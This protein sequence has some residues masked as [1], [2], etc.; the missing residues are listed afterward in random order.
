MN[1]PNPPPFPET[2]DEIR[3]RFAEV[4]R[5]FRAPLI[6]FLQR[7]VGNEHCAADLA[8]E[9]LVKS[10]FQLDHFDDRR[11]FRPWLFTIAANCG[12][13][14]IRKHS[15]SPLVADEDAGESTS[16]QPG[17]DRMMEA[18]ERKEALDAAI[19]LLPISLRQ[20]ILLHYQLDWPVAEISQHLGIDQGAVKT[21]LHRARQRLNTLL[22][23]WKTNA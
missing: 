10:Y 9:T 20:P 22:T 8:Q 16:E 4:V 13:D 6:T 14:Y 17:P 5:Q 15:R 21:R 11:P 19:A 7:Y 1:E 3:V 12:R 18:H 23:P 2:R